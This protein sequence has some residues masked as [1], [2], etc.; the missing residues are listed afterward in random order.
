MTSGKHGEIE[1]GVRENPESGSK[2]FSKEKD[3]FKTFSGTFPP[4]I[5]NPVKNACKKN[6]NIH[7]FH[8]FIQFQ[9]YQTKHA[10]YLFQDMNCAFAEDQKILRDGNE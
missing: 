4:K 1:I 9:R 6:N 5:R 8:F 3:K 7:K 10:K 2:F